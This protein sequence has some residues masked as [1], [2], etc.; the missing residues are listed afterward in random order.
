MGWLLVRR[1][2]APR[3][4]SWRW[5][6]IGDCW[7]RWFASDGPM[8]VVPKQRFLLWPFV[9]GAL[10]IGIFIFDSISPLEFAVAVLYVVVVLIAATSQE[11]RFIWTTAGACV[12]LTILS[13]PLAHGLKIAGTA[14]LRSIMSLVAIGMTTF[15]S[16]KNLSVTQRLRET[17]R[18]RTNL[19][20][21]FSPQR[22]EQLLEIDTPLSVA[23][24][25]PAAVLFVD[26]I[27]STAYFSRMMPDAVIGILRDL[28]SLLSVSV[29]AHNGTIDKFLGDG[30]MAV[31]GAP[32]PSAVDA[33]NA[34]RCALDIQ[35]C[36][37]RWNERC[38]RTGDAA[39][40]VA[41]GV[42]YGDVV[43]GDVGSDNHL[44]LT[45]VG[46]TVNTDSRVEAYC[47][48]FEAAV[49]VTGAFVDC[50]YAE[51]SEKVAERF[52]DQGHHMLRGRAEPIHLYGVRRKLPPASA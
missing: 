13:Y 46:D 43:Q 39:I 31:F 32:V 12:A 45:V 42:H 11:R 24:D 18:Q 51:G 7:Q 29:F 5:Q 36:I 38:D 35:E 48:S 27:G 2:Q 17:E 28:L 25:Q 19:A 41:V 37:D 23:R 6:C 34:A 14:P 40:H 4:S 15:L 47:R 50:L 26:M 3:S 22:V 10:G 52:A 30:L 49:L 20:R 21:F 9:A 16:L 44:E 1:S 33:T 8:L